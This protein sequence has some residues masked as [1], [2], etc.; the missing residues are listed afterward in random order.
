MKADTILHYHQVPGHLL[1]VLGP[2]AQSHL[3]SEWD[4]A[5]LPR[6]THLLPRAS[7]LVRVLSQG[8]DGEQ[9]P[10]AV[11]LADSGCTLTCN[12]PTSEGEGPEGPEPAKC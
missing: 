1:G 7:W 5:F 11:A 2:L 4:M 6:A 12:M 8:V 9:C 10:G 3:P